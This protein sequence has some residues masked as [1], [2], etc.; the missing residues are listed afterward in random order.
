MLQVKQWE[1][2]S[3]EITPF[4]CVRV[5]SITELKLWFHF[6]LKAKYQHGLLPKQEQKITLTKSVHES[7]LYLLNPILDLGFSLVQEPGYLSSQSQLNLHL[8]LTISQ[9][10][11]LI[12][13]VRWQHKHTI[14]RA[15]SLSEAISVFLSP[16]YTK[17]NMECCICSVRLFILHRIVTRL[18]CVIALGQ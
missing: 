14:L 4:L 2:L 12:Y 18:L 8:K 10:Q 11:I 5:M 16:F 1:L 3:R 6:Q 9:N 13:V 7:V 15:F 17:A